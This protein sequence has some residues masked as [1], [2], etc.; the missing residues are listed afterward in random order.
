MTSVSKK[1]ILYED[2]IWDIK[3]IEWDKYIVWTDRKWKLKWIPYPE[4]I[5]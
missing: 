2:N 5:Y 1:K 4:R 3:W